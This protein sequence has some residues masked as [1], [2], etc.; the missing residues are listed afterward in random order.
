MTD[1]ALSMNVYPIG[2]CIYI[3][4]FIDYLYFENLYVY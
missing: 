3:Y 1:L 2:T 4:I